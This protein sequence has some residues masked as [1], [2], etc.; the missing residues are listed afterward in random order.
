MVIHIDP[1]WVNSALFPTPI[2]DQ[3]QLKEQVG[4]TM[5]HELFHALGYRHDTETTEPYTIWPFSLTNDHR[6]GKVSPVNPNSCIEW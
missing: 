2:S 4:L 1:A 6:V 5:I 3:L